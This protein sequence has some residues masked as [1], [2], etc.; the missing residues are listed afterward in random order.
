MW[1]GNP[2]QIGWR[3]SALG[4]VLLIILIALDDWFS[5]PPQEAEIDFTE[6]SLVSE[7][8]FS[9]LISQ[10]SLPLPNEQELQEKNGRKGAPPPL[11][12]LEILSDPAPVDKALAPNNG[13][14]DAEKLPLSDK[15][16]PPLPLAESEPARPKAAEIVAPTLVD[17][18]NLSAQ[19]SLAQ[20]QEVF[21]DS[22]TSRVD[23]NLKEQPE[24]APKET[25]SVLETEANREK[26]TVAGGAPPTSPRPQGR[27]APELAVQEESAVTPSDPVKENVVDD[28]IASILADEA[29]SADPV[30][31]LPQI[32]AQEAGALRVA[33]QQCWNVGAL[34]SNA[35]RVTVTVGVSLERN[36]VPDAASIRMLSFSGGSEASAKSA[37]EAARRAI[38]RCGARG[39]PLPL[40]KYEQ[41]RDI[42]LVFDP[43]GMKLR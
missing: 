9:E 26:D 4:H 2:T 20:Q 31:P 36:G 15:D 38:I 22:N 35:L 11:A 33:V 18:P 16:I 14:E 30:V 12:P 10:S 37:Y 6:V 24:E 29:L 1:R 7:A 28:L 3:I 8:Q 19:E 34:S 40:E 42:E 32:S 43:N 41:W 39:F 23:K 13:V 17:T 25:G 27:P 21:A 5:R